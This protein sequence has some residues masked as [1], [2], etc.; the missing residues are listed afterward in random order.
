M[1]A[2]QTSSPPIT[3]ILANPRGIPTIKHTATAIIAH[4]CMIR[5]YG[6]GVSSM[7]RRPATKPTRMAGIIVVADDTYWTGNVMRTVSP[8]AN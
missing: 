7:P 6:S 3:P 4:Q 1:I 2:D 5:R 8:M